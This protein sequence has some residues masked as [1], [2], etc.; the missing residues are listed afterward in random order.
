MSK[1]LVY[2]IDDDAGLTKIIEKRFLSM[3]CEIQS[4]TDPD[5]LLRAFGERK[6]QLLLVDI[7]LGGG[8]SGLDIISQ[9]R[10]KYPT[11]MPILVLSGDEDREQIAR[12]IDLGANEYIVK[13][14]FRVDFEEIVSKFLTTSELKGSGPVTFQMIHPKKRGA[15]LGFKISIHEVKSN[16]F[17]VLSPHLAKKGATFHIKGLD[18]QKIIPD[19]PG[20]FVEVVATKTLPGHGLHQLSLE[21]DSSQVKVLKGIKKFLDA[22]FLER[23]SEGDSVAPEEAK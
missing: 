12:A 19:C 14:P 9:V 11:D 3:G 13:P 17:T 22:K 7:Y 4:Y 6:P 16:G 2:F 5:T 18:L 8:L 23:N 20:A 10:A 1:P 21:V 15:K